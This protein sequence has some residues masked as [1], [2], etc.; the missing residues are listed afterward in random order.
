MAIRVRH[1]YNGMGDYWGGEGARHN[2][3]GGCL[4]AFYGPSTT[5][6]EIVDELCDDY[7]SGGDCDSFPAE[8][9][10][11]MVREAIMQDML[12]DRGR[13]DVASGAIAECAAYYAACNDYDKCRGCGELIGEEHDEECAILDECDSAYVEEED[14]GPEDGDDCYES[15]IFVAFVEVDICP[16]CGGYAEDPDMW[17]NGLCNEC[18][19]AFGNPT[20]EGVEL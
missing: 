4:F 10:M 20:D 17:D 12:N 3:N 5:L 2:D 7:W 19:E 13:A 6:A 1:E 9:S 11:E 18:N 8:V 14:C 15:P 16:C